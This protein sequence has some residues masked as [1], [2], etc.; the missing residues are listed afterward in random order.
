[1]LRMQPSLMDIYSGGKLG[2]LQGFQNWLGPTLG[3]S[4]QQTGLNS[5][6]VNLGGT[7]PIT[8]PAPGPIG[9]PDPNKVGINPP[10]FSGGDVAPGGGFTNPRI[11]PVDYGKGYGS[12]FGGGFSGGDVAPGGGFTNP[13]VLPPG[14]GKGYFP[15]MMNIYR[16]NLA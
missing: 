10:T 11:L 1:M 14:Y 12:G 5:K 6:P 9:I 13:R 7:L 16:G 4:G 15:S 3:G 8:D 2:G